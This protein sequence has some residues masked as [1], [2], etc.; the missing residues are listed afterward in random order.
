MEFGG[1]V[2]DKVY[3]RIS[4]SDDDD[5]DQRQSGSK[6]SSDS[7]TPKGRGRTQKR[8]SRKSRRPRSNRHGSELGELDLMSPPLPSAEAGQ[9]EHDRMS[10]PS[11]RQEK[12]SSDNDR[13][14]AQQQAGAAG[15]D[16]VATSVLKGLLDALTAMAENSRKAGVSSSQVPRQVENA[17]KRWECPKGVRTPATFDLEQDNIEIFLERF[18]T[19][20]E[21]SGMPEEKQATAL[22]ELMLSL[23]HI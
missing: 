17:P 15:V 19:F 12:I 14:G 4:A 6:K 2:S 20:V 11:Q 5:K 23:I 21:D 7:D 16:T 18:E 3:K 8:A 13:A 22:L 1:E 9:G 10:H